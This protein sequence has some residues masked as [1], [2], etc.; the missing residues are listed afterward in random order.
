VPAFTVIEAFGAKFAVTVASELPNVN[1][2]GLAVV[3]E[4]EPPPALL[5]VHEEK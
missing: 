3:E 2:A 5:I 1:V 4:I